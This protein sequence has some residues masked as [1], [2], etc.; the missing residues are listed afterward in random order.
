MARLKDVIVF[1]PGIMGSVLQRNGKDVW[2]P[3]AGG[4]LNAVAS[5]LN[6]I[7]SLRLQSD[8]TDQAYLDD[9]VIAT[10]VMPSAHIIPGLWKIDGYT[11]TS[12]AIARI[13]DNVK[14]GRNYFEFPYDWRRDNRV[15]AK[16][17]QVHAEDWLE[18]WRKA[19]DGDPNGKLILV[20]HSMGGLVSRYYLEVLGGWRL[21]RALITFGTPYSG[22]LNALNF[23]A[24]GYKKAF[25]LIDLSEMLRS[26]TSIYQLLPNYKCCDYGDGELLRVDNPRGIPNVDPVRVAA[27]F[28]FHQEIADSQAANSKLPEYST[29]GYRIYPVVGTHQ[30]TLQSARIV[31]GSSSEVRLISDYLGQDYSGDGTVP[32][33][34]ATPLEWADS[35][36][37]M[38]VADKHASLQYSG[39]VLEHLDGVLT[40]LYME[41]AIQREVVQIEPDDDIQRAVE[42]ATKGSA[43]MVRLSVAIDDAFEAGEPILLR[44]QADRATTMLKAIVETANDRVFVHEEDL[45]FSGNTYR[46]ELA[47]LPAGLYRITIQGDQNVLPVSDLFE[48]YPGAVEEQRSLSTSPMLWKS[49]PQGDLPLIQWTDNIVTI[50]ATEKGAALGHLLEGAP[51]Y[52]VITHPDGWHVALKPSEMSDDLLAAG[53]L[54]DRLHRNEASQG[55]YNRMLP[56]PII[57]VSASGSASRFVLMSQQDEPLSVGVYPEGHSFIQGMPSVVANTQSLD[58][59]AQSLWKPALPA[60]QR[61]DLWEP[62]E[63]R[64]TKSHSMAEPPEAPWEPADAAA[65]PGPG[66]PWEAEKPAAEE[67]AAAAAPVSAWEAEEPEVVYPGAA[68]T[69]SRASAD[70]DWDAILKDFAMTSAMRGANDVFPAAAAPSAAPEEPQPPPES[71]QETVVVTRYPSI[72]MAGEIRAGGEVMVTVD[73][74]L[75]RDLLTQTTGVII[76]L[77]SN[78]NEVPIQV[79]LVAP[80]LVT[81]A[82][83]GAIM[84]R[85]GKASLPWRL[86]TTIVE[87][88]AGADRVSLHASFA[89]NGRTIGSARRAF[90]LTNAA[91]IPTISTAAVPAPAAPAP[92][93]EMVVEF[94]DAAIP[95]VSAKEI[96]TATTSGNFSLDT[97]VP[98]PTMTIEIYSLD[99]QMMWHLKFPDRVKEECGNLPR[100]FR[101]ILT[102]KIGND[103]VD[104][105]AY[106]DS[107]FRAAGSLSAPLHKSFFKGLGERL[108]ELT[109]KCFKDA[110]WELVRVYGTGFPIQIISDDP[111]IPWELIRLGDATHPAYYLGV[112]HPVARWFMEYEGQR[113]VRIA[114]GRVATTAPDYKKR[115]PLPRLAAA[116][117]ESQDILANLPGVAVAISGDKGSFLE[118]FEDAKRQDIALIHYAG[119]GSCSTNQTDMAFLVLENG[120]VYVYDLRNS[121]VTLGMNRHPLVFL[122][123]CQVG[124]SGLNLGVIGGF[125]EALMNRQFGG[126]VAPLWSVYDDPAGT[127]STTFIKDVL[128]GSTF[129]EALRKIRAQFGDE[130]PTFLSYIYYGDVMAAYC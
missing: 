85:N 50:A 91:A 70:I 63:P 57:F 102:L 116:L 32:R 22:S 17:L 20:A 7:Q 44:V 27:A 53:K 69:F 107:L 76:N 55:I 46:V 83:D 47:P 62:Y 64:E 2:A 60:A 41:Q 101:E 21:T 10:R 49:I 87:D 127:C 77:P 9:G 119:H 28:A 80:Q 11:E 78:W 73:L 124:K 40:G 114:R 79:N 29:N 5:G 1:L 38:F 89:Y 96:P 23:L 123:A 71:A 94:V 25:N 100:S 31:A 108:Y 111:Y 51:E 68:A 61:E 66:G 33:V 88:L 130:S 16:W 110:Y 125:A 4:F 115:P 118:M 42:D 90:M 15:A 45:V 92:P 36:L 54:A 34:S 3:S 35:S 26:F 6:D 43:G 39:P 13:F 14:P 121:D 74:A 97:S 48:V 65:A 98:P 106:V 93:E 52:V 56:P 19:S 129:A 75:V 120:D 95:A 81:S 126:L 103:V 109:P 8:P 59:R 30:P 58:V 82:A 117:R 122:N 112:S 113:P 128:S 67:P 104:A 37:G 105:P 18:D 84:I 72:D 99:K 86:K 12:E 24:N